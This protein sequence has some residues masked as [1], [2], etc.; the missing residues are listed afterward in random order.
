METGKLAGSLAAFRKSSIG[1]GSSVVGLIGKTRYFIPAASVAACSAL[2]SAPPARS[3][4]VLIPRFFSAGIAM[5]RDVIEPP[6]DT[7]LSTNQ[8]LL[9]PGT[10]KRLL[11][12]AGDMTGKPA[13]MT[14]RPL[15][16]NRFRFIGGI[17][18]PTLFT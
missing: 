2:L 10:I 8:K 6:V 12:C 17:L 11:F 3:I 15:Q 18:A 5:S 13:S 4:T 7:V 14:R 1:A 9:M 16:R